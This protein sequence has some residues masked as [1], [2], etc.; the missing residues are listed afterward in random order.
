MFQLLRRDAGAGVF[1]FKDRHFTHVSYPECHLAALGELDGVAEDVDEDLS[2]S[3][4]IG[5]HGQR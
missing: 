2:Q 3:P 1:D 5:T 4:F